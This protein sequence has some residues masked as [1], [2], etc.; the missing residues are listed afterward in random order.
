MSRGH[1]GSAVVRVAVSALRLHLPV[2]TTSFVDT[3]LFCFGFVGI[4]SRRIDVLVSC[5]QIS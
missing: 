5:E 3:G 2:P 4:S 1:N